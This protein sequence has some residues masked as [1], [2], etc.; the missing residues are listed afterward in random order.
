MKKLALVFIFIFL[1]AGCSSPQKPLRLHIIANSNSETDQNIKL[2][3]RDEILEYT[4]NG[5]LKCENMEEAKEY[6]CEELDSICGVANNVLSENGFD[7]SATATLGIS[8]FPEKTYAG[9][10]Y[11][12]GEYEALK[13]VI[14]Q[15]EG[16][17]WWCVVFPPLCLVNTD[18]SSDSSPD[19]IEYKSAI[20]E[21]FCSIFG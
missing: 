21:W 15:G 5:I 6:I 13:I 2:T 19:E 14:G 3:V 1:L 9:T 8:H 7:Y 10:T 12:E 16:E 11:P 4:S 18:I 17:N 20:A